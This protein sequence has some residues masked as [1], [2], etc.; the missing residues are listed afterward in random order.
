MNAALAQ[1]PHILASSTSNPFNVIWSTGL[2]VLEDFKVNGGGDGSSQTPGSV[3]T[4]Q[5]GNTIYFVNPN[6]SQECQGCTMRNVS[7]INSIANAVFWEYAEDGLIDN[8][9]ITNCGNVGIVITGADG[10]APPNK[11]QPCTT[12]SITGQT[13]IGACYYA[14]AI[15][16]NTGVCIYVNAVMQQT[17][18][19]AINGLNNRC[20]TFDT[21]YQEWI[22]GQGGS[23]G[24]A[25]W[26]NL[27]PSTCDGEGLV[28]NNCFGLTGVLYTA[29]WTNVAFVG[30]TIANPG[31]A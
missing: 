19:V 5:V 27:N 14:P 28:F 22:Q 16:I 24:P 25:Y 17:Q 9:Y 21:C 30:G 10:T 6:G 13:W 8:C 11:Y 1:P 31:W 12:V 18:G 20:I 3:L 29:N 15:V 4:A 2:T 26:V 7:I 23:S